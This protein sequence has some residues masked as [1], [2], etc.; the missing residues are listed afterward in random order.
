MREQIINFSKKNANNS[1]AIRY[2]PHLTRL[3]LSLSDA[4]YAYNIV[5]E[6]IG[7][8]SKTQVKR[9][10][11][12]DKNNPGKDPDVYI[13]ILQSLNGTGPFNV[14]L[15][16]DG[17][18]CVEGIQWNTSTGKIVAF[19]EISDFDQIKNSINKK[20]NTIS[21]ISQWTVRFIL[22]KHQF[23]CSH[24][25]HANEPTAEELYLE[26]IYVIR[27]LTVILLYVVAIVIDAG[28]GNTKFFRTCLLNHKK[29]PSDFW[30][31]D[32]DVVFQHPFI[33]EIKIVCIFCLVHG[34]K[35]LRNALVSEKR[36]LK[37]SSGDISINTVEDIYKEDLKLNV[38]GISINTRLK[39]IYL[40]IYLY[41][42][43]LFIFYFI[44]FL[45]YF[46]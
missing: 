6:E 17:F 36:K 24:F 7:L 31:K 22:G 12:G 46:N 3:A 2:S 15:L 13:K 27:Q 19:E 28:G 18:K 41:Y 29:T 34:M 16:N 10:R 38:D 42:C 5:S 44:Y 14:Q 25:Y 37:S 40:F 1:S 9:Y 11:A 23:M 26:F 21:H 43:I 20:K 33:P 32:E 35:A 4:P 39:L 8:M 30:L 45:F